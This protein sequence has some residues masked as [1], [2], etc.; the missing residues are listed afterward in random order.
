MKFG[1]T[2]SGDG[3]T[4]HNCKLAK[5]KEQSCK[6]ILKIATLKCTIFT[7]AN[8]KAAKDISEKDQGD[9]VGQKKFL[10]KCLYNPVLSHCQE[11]GIW[12]LVYVEG[13]GIFCGVS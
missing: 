3:E 6:S 12:S 8:K 13:Y 10:Y 2:F 7:F 5:I 1:L 4:E 11:T 9:M